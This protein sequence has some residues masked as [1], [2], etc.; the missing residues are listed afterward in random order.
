MLAIV[1]RAPHAAV[2]AALEHGG[3]GDVGPTSESGW[4]GVWAEGAAPLMALGDLLAIDEDEAMITIEAGGSSTTWSWEHTGD[5]RP[6]E[7][8]GLADSHEF[9]LALC[10]LFGQS[11]HRE[12]AAELLGRSP[13]ATEIWQLLED[14]FSLAQLDWPT[15]VRAVTLHR[16]DP[17]RRGWRGGWSRATSAQ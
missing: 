1:V 6:R 15:P 14:T 5:P 11:E 13:S 16:G 3:V 4:P 10:E 8:S 2:V 12:V 9:A 7:A 17:R